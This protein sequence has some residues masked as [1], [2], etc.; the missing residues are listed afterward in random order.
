MRRKAWL[1]PVRIRTPICT[2]GNGLSYARS[3]I[4]AV[5]KSPTDI[6]SVSH[7]ES[8]WKKTASVR[9]FSTLNYFD[10]RLSKLF[11]S[12]IA[13]GSSVIEIGCGGS[14]W[15]G[16]FD[17]VMRCET[18]GIDYS[19]EGL[20]ITERSNSG[21]PRVRLVAGD[22]F[23]QSALPSEYFDFIYSLG[24]I[25]HFTDAE[26]VTRRMFQILR[27]GGRVMTL[28]P[29]FLSA[30][31]T[32][33]KRVNRAT[34]DK[35]VIMTTTMLDDAHLAGGLTAVD[36]ARFFGCFAPGVIDYGLWQRLV[37]PPIRLAQHLACWSLHGLHLDRES[38]LHSPYIVGVYEKQNV[39]T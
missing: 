24:F 29:N 20:A 39:L 35:H 3:R 13:P 12:L 14:R 31:G 5:E 10:F 23:D 19:A 4:K 25:E 30:Y 7:W 8:V 6:A 15:I 16:Y 34:F 33:Q 9:G 2:L 27:P 37:L 1:Q 21:R 18:W 22:F 36:S 26:L 11:Q 38:R 17:R 28:V 32:I